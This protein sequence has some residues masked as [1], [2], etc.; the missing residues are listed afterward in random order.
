[1]RDHLPPGVDDL[2][3]AIAADR[4]HGASWL[5]REALRVMGECAARSTAASPA[6]LERELHA[7]ARALRV[8]R[9]GMAPVRFWIQRLLDA[10]QPAMAAATDLAPLRG[11][12]GQLVDRLIAESE[13][14]VHRAARQAVD[15]LTS[16]TVIATASYSQTILLALCLAWEAGTL[17]RVV[18]AESRAP[19]GRRYGADL[20]TALQP[21]GIPVEL[22]PDD[23]IPTRIASAERVWL[24]ADSVLIDGSVLNGTPSATLAS[25][26]HHLGRPVEV[27]SELAK[28]DCW[29]DPET[30]AVPA[31]FDRI[32]AE[33]I[34]AVVTER[35]RLAPR[36]LSQL[37]CQGQVPA[38]ASA[39][40]VTTN[41]VLPWGDQAAP[42]E[43]VARIAGRLT[44]RGET[45]AVAESSAGGRICDLLTDRPGSSAWFMGGLIA[46]SNL[47]KQRVAGLT[48]EELAQRGAV[49][50]ETAAALAA[51]VRHLFGASWGVGETGIAG[52]Q[53]GRRSSKPAGLSYVAIIGPGNVQA[54]REV[55][56]GLDDRA[57]NKR[58][59]ALA[60][61]ALLVEHVEGAP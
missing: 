24:G 46:Y 51:G 35:G 7:C 28:V 26:A 13:Q 37:V 23:Q 12:I 17:R 56:T 1:M 50:P 57:A 60:A 22:I 45:L 29:S 25:A 33:W 15:Q 38:E 40:P 30:L 61:L 59:F 34:S 19:G 6:Q 2:I 47:S 36:Q 14:A 31:G 53:T 8:A 58:A 18:A 32:P 16:P 9:P 10:A 49:S 42:S 43:L 39:P 54:T 5:A 11:R 20:E 44:A 52:P 21:A 3:A 41:P 27:I 4:T 48:A 55:T